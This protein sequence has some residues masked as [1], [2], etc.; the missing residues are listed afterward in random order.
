MH[1]PWDPEPS[2]ASQP[3]RDRGKRPFLRPAVQGGWTLQ[4]CSGQLREQA[5][6]L[7]KGF[8]SVS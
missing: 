4:M 3:A 8:S 2:R 5:R 1:L 6:S 7:G